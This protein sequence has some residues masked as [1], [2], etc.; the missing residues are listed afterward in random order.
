MTGLLASFSF[1]SSEV[2]E[3]GTAHDRN[4]AAY[5]ESRNDA[6]PR[7]YEILHIGVDS[8][9]SQKALQLLN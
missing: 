8:R 6:V 9:V 1:T 4:F 3:R 7:V 5:S 2:N